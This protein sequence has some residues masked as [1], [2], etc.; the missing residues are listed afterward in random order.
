MIDL[1]RILN[2][3]FHFD[4]ESFQFVVVVLFFK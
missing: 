3:N 1:S 2:D 4:L